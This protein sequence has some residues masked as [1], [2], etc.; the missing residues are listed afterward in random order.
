M[1]EHPGCAWQLPSAE[2]SNGLPLWIYVDV[3]LCTLF[4]PLDE[5]LLLLWASISLSIKVTFVSMSCLELGPSFTDSDMH[6]C[7][8]ILFTFLENI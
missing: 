6:H 5:V 3:P 2:E 1:P 7:L 4:F 8:T